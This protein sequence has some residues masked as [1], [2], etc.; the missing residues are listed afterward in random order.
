MRQELTVQNSPIHTP[1]KQPG[2][3]SKMNRGKEN[4]GT[5]KK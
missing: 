5:P 2:Y 4:L 3:N 1:H